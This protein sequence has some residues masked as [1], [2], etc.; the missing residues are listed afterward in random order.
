M[1]KS[2]EKLLYRF[3]YKNGTRSRGGFKTFEEASH[4][5]NNCKHSGIYANLYSDLLDIV[6]WDYK[7]INKG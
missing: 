3:R 4:C 1:G 2:K 7:P 5:F 6:P